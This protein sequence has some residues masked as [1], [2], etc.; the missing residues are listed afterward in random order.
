MKRELNIWVAGGDMRQV[1]LA[2]LLE[3]DGHT[4]HIYALKAEDTPGLIPES[5]L[6]RIGLADCVILPLPV[7]AGSGHGKA[8]LVG[9]GLI[10]FPNDP[11][12]KLCVNTADFIVLSCLRAEHAPIIA[13]IADIDLQ[14]FRKRRIYGLFGKVSLLIQIFVFE[15]PPRG[16]FIYESL[17]HLQNI[18]LAALRMHFLRDGVQILFKLGDRNIMLLGR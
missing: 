3:E 10:R 2:S 1:K 14:Y 13:C 16:F 8:Q 4:V 5:S 18:R 12:A 15:P 7:S 6:E 9:A 17:I 11:A